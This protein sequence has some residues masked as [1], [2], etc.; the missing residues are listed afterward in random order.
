MRATSFLD[1]AG[2]GRGGNFTSLQ[3]LSR[4]RRAPAEARLI[5]LVFAS[6]SPL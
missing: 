4:V 5:V 6:I 1:R 2:R 3:P